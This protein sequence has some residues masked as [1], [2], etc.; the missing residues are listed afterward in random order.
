VNTTIVP[1]PR[2]SRAIRNALANDHL[3]R[4]DGAPSRFQFE[5]VASERVVNVLAYG[6]TVHGRMPAFIGGLWDFEVQVESVK[7]DA[8]DV[9]ALCWIT[10][11][12][13]G[14]EVR[15]GVLFGAGGSFYMTRAMP[16]ACDPQDLG[17]ALATEILSAGKFGGQNRALTDCASGDA[18]SPVEYG[19]MQA[20]DMGAWSAAKAVAA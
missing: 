17:V 19:R 16:G 18:V 10:E 3:L 12:A 8:C 11:C 15:I 4:A 9:A 6:L 2:E 1:D 14:A 5:R 13:T 20:K 7:A